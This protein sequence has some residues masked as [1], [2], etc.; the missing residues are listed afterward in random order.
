MPTPTYT[1]I[2]SNTLSAS[3]ASVT[4]SSI[5]ST[6]TDLVLRVSMRHDS[7]ATLF[8]I[9]VRFNGDTATNYSRTFLTGDGAS[10]SSSRNTSSAFAR[11]LM[12]DAATATANTF[13]SGEI[14]I[15]NYTASTNKPL[16]SFNAQED[17]STTAYI[18]ANAALWQNTAAINQISIF[19]ATSSGNFVAGSSFYLYGL[20]NS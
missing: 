6:Y 11:I 3:A 17:N 5:P 2:A 13:A 7:A 18:T 14:Y 19:P 20:K 9:D 10:P 15:P 8:N 16:S 4:F 1:L 12:A